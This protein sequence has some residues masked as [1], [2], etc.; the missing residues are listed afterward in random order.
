LKGLQAVNAIR[1]PDDV[2]VQADDP[3]RAKPI[4]V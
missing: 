4:F 3:K 2:V 1:S